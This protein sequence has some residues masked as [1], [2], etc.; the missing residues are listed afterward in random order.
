MGAHATEP[1]AVVEV[2][3]T[4][5]APPEQVFDAWTKP[6]M[7]AKWLCRVPTGPE[8]KVQIVELRP[9]GRLQLEA[10]E[11]TGVVWR[12]RSEYREVERPK[13]LVFTWK[14]EGHDEKGE[15]LVTVEFHR[16]GNSNFTEVILRHEG[17]PNAKECADHRQG[18]TECLEQLE[19]ILAQ[20]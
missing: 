16:L 5:A 19:K 4:F 8:V 1:Q 6:E 9:G 2:R 7:M 17:L 11:P 10:L 3:R 18:W 14:W 13:R 20:A 12:L 15:S